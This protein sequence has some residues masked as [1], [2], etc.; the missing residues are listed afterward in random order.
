MRKT[1]HY[2]RAIVLLCVLALAPSQAFAFQPWG[3]PLGSWRPASTTQPVDVYSNGN[4]EWYPERL[5]GHGKK[6]QCV[7]YVNRYYAAVY[8][9]DIEGGDAKYYFKRAPEKGL[10][11]FPNGGAVAPR[12]GDI[13]CSEGGP[14][15]HVA[16]VR[17]VGPDGIHIVQQNWYN[18]AR[19]LDMVLPLTAKGSTY[20]LGAFAP[21]HPICGWL[22]APRAAV[23]GDQQ[24]SP[25][26]SIMPPV[27]SPAKAQPVLSKS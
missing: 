1:I 2:T 26:K 18:D 16:I 7:E 21:S 27:G 3:T 10:L 9:M 11:A 23:P 8:G 15:G 17:S 12:V 24:V 13:L 14:F 20:S 4:W 5:S 22:R 25:A 6:W 19:D